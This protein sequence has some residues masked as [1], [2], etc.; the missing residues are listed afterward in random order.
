MKCVLMVCILFV[1]FLMVGGSVV[2]FGIRIVGR[3]CI[4]VSVIMVVGSFL[5]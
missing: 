2:L 5:L 4:V 1:F 3:L